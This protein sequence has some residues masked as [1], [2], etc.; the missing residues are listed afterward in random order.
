MRIAL[1]VLNPEH[2]PGHSSAALPKNCAG[3]SVIGAI[4]ISHR[5][6]AAG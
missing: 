1:K 4:L 5:D 3:S 6:I 2:A